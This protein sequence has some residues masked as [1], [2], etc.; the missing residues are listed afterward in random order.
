MDDTKREIKPKK[1]VIRIQNHLDTH[2]EQ[3]FEGM[4]LKHTGD[5]QTILSGEVEDQ[6]ALLGLLEKIHNLNVTL[7]SVRKAGYSS[8]EHK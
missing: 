3:W 4:T 7:I 6:S 8:H 5:G 2:W 1:Y